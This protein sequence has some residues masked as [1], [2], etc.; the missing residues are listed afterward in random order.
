VRAGSEAL[1]VRP[2]RHTACVL[3]NDLAIEDCRP[4]RKLACRCNNAGVSVA[5]IVPIAGMGASGTALNQEHG[6]IAVMLHLMNP[7][8]AFRRLV[9]QAR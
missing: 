7:V 1:P 8:S 4:A 5:P 6:P 2:R 9:G 3:H